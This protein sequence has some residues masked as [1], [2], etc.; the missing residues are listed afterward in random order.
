MRNRV[1]RA[2]RVFRKNGICPW[3]LAV[4]VVFVTV[5]GAPAATLHVSTGS[6]ADGPGTAWSNAFHTI[7]G[8][9]NASTNGDTILVT[10]GVYEAGSAVTPGYVLANRVCLTNAVTVRSVNGPSNTFIVGAGPNGAA[11]L[12]CVYLQ[13]NTFL[14]GF[15]LTNG[16]TATDGHNFYDKS[17]GGA[18]L[19]EGGTI[20]NCMVTG[21]GAVFGG[22]GIFCWR[23]PCVV[24]NTRVEGNASEGY[25]GGLYFR[26]GGAANHCLIMDNSCVYNGAGV[27]CTYTGILNNCL[28]AGNAA[29][30][31][32]GG[33]YGAAHLRN[34]TIIDNTASNGAGGHYGE[35][36]SYRN[37]I[38]YRNTAAISNNWMNGGAGSWTYCCTTPLPPGTGNITNDPMLVGFCNAHLMPGSPCINTGLNAYAAGSRDI[39]GEPRTNGF[40]DIGCDEF[41]IGGAAGPLSVAIL[42]DWTNAVPGYTLSF[43]ADIQGT[44]STTRWDCGDGG[45]FTNIATLSHAWVTAGTFGVRL[46]AYNS[47]NV[48]GVAA[49]VTVNIVAFTN[50]VSPTGG[51]VAPYT[52]W[53]TASTTLQDA[54]D[55]CIYNGGTV[56]ATDGV[57][58]AGGRVA[59]G[60]LNRVAVSLPITVRSVNGAANTVIRGASARWAEAVRC[61]YLSGGAALKGFT[62]ADGCTTY[63]SAENVSY[64]GGGAFL[65]GSGLLADC[66]IVSNASYWYGGGAMCQEGGT[67]SNCLVQG[68][69]AYAHGGGG[70]GCED[71]GLV[72]HCTIIE[73]YS[74]NYANGGGVR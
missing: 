38:I 20:S 66:T 46:T 27:M 28:V 56:L 35:S 1:E 40:V 42:A 10:N 21:N 26:E 67:I 19:N 57:Y 6:P 61:V 74:S 23:E 65:D 37:T 34:C 68:N 59:R 30:Y 12:R 13:T 54:V 33:V 16:H 45:A 47:D 15:T 8:A 72:T 9:V 44:A 14:I 5:C 32:G 39:D 69:F 60:N 58:S 2:W 22:A 7:Q 63:S 3:A 31:W 11:A 64:T 25:C 17:G 24:N 18:F 43:T 51:H 29:G 41:W 55:A 53:A 70:V 71:G 62:L 50:Y 73:N 48:G 36:A 4:V 52:S 49:T